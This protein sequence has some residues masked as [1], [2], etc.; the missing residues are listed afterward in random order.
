MTVDATSE[1]SNS[2]GEA[3]KMSYSK[4]GVT[5]P[6]PL[7]FKC[8]A[9]GEKRQNPCEGCTNSN[10][11]MTDGL[12]IKEP[13]VDNMNE[14]QPVVKIGSDGSVKACAKGDLSQCGYKP[15]AKVCGKCGAMA[16]QVKK[17]A[18]AG[19]ADYGVGMEREKDEEVYDEDNFA[20]AKKK[21]AGMGFCNCPEYK[22]VEGGL[23][24][25]CGKPQ[26]P[27]QMKANYNQG[28]SYV[29]DPMDEDYMARRRARHKKRMASMGM[30]DA[31]MEGDEPT[32]AALVEA[33]RRIMGSVVNL[34]FSAHAA[35]WN[36]E[37]PD[38][39]QYHE[40]FG[41]IYSDVQA[42]IDP[43]AENI[44]KLG[45]PAPAGLAS[46]A[47]TNPP[48]A[49]NSPR[50]L[51][52]TLIMMNASIISMMKQAFTVADEL[53]EQG[54]AD[55]LAGRI[56]T[57]QKWQWF[58]T[59]SAKTNEMK[60]LLEEI[61]IKS[62]E[63]SATIVGGDY[64]MCASTREIK[65][66][67]GASPC[68]DCT[69]GCMSTDHR[70]DLLEVEAMAEDIIG[71][72]TLFSAYADEFDVFA[73]QV[74]RKDGQPVEVF[75]TGDG[76]LDGWIRI[77]ES[78]IYTKNADVVDL[79]T[80][81]DTAL[82][83]IEGKALSVAVGRFEQEEAYIVEVDGLDGKSYDV[84]IAPNGTL[85]GFDERQTEEKRAFSTERRQT[86]ADAGAALPDGSYPI[87]SEA[88]LRNAI[89]AYGRAKDKE[90]AKAHII[91]RAKKLGLDELLP[92]DWMS[93]DDSGEKSAIDGDL[94]AA[95]VELE[96]LELDINED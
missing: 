42:S 87:V 12:Q 91:K 48:M 71:G 30:K 47:G 96:L 35:H 38:F 79:G 63:E 56:D 1:S 44:R 11:C 7:K 57:H 31:E 53:N 6:T 95:L 60:S 2:A 49:N 15:G 58:L 8:M 55:F 77:P 64:F 14:K 9:T 39:S 69:G 20:V 52:G 4:P 25:K 41:E 46:F 50:A 76:Q 67:I 75:F 10:T 86:L 85:L 5:L 82:A 88:D 61:D 17:G 78:A 43:F 29:D 81:V 70:P 68:G 23:C 94:T 32:V 33:L 93:S 22:G 19:D 74:R 28:M 36:V 72:K 51:V 89:Q 54:V 40:L 59:S 92:E 13:T 62:A 27:V 83:T 26:A 3:S 34:Y 45:A 16:V 21:Q 84:A 24:E 37:G 18:S 73:V 66:V 90:A 80:A 65:S